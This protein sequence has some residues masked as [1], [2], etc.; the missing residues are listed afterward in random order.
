MTDPL[1]GSPEV[2]LLLPKGDVEEPEMSIVIPALNEALTIK[3]FIDWCWEGLRKANIKGEIL[4]VDSSTDKTD[5]MALSAGARVLKTP[6][7]G[8]GRA[9][10]DAIDY[11]RSPFVLMGDCDCT[12]DF[13]ELGVFMKEFRQGYDFIMGTRFKGYIEPKAMPPLHR[14]FG[15]PVTTAIL[16]IMY[17]TRFSDIHCGMRGITLSALRRISLQS[18]GWEYASEMILKA[19]KMKLKTTEV[20]VR[21]YKDPPG[22]LS[23]HKRSGWTSP[24]L[25][26]WVNLRVM[27]I[28]CPEF[29]LFK[30]GLVLMVL[31]L[32]FTGVL[33]GGTFF[34]G[35]LGFS[36]HSMLFGITLATTGFSSMQL[37]LLSR[38]Y[39]NFDP[40][41]TEKMEK[42][43]TYNR[44]VLIGI[45][46]VFVGFGLTCPLIHNWCKSGFKLFMFHN[47]ALFG[48]LL[49][50]LGFQL[51][52]F[53]L[54][55]EIITKGLA[56]DKRG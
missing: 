36:L 22:R 46:M 1:K 33:T 28:F 5:Q 3:Q 54:M 37:G 13:R 38:V 9:Y 40:E 8:L 17:G 24:W 26:G 29:F 20:P 34:I 14:Y 52:T 39:H 45:V 18:Q 55:F 31:G 43:L 35:H 48:L 4:I 25:A 27:F 23:H 12:Y 30:P 11:I 10:I 56:H 49:I 42:I 44:G 15:T 32:I 19:A 2:H 21:F 47:Y 16:N 50:I 6:K 53:T 51:F 7:R 41:F